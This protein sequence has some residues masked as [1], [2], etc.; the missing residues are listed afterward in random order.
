MSRLVNPWSYVPV[1][2][3]VLGQIS[4]NPKVRNE[5]AHA[6]TQI[7]SG[8]EFDAYIAH[9]YPDRYAVTREHI[10]IAK[11]QLEDDKLAAIA[12]LK[13]SG[14]LLMVGMGWDFEVEDPDLINNYRIRGE[15]RNSKGTLFFIEVGKHK[16]NVA[17]TDIF[18]MRCDH[19]INRDIEKLAD[20][21]RQMAG[22]SVCQSKYYNWK[23]LESAPHLGPYTKSRLLEIVNWNFDCRFTGVE[24]DNYTLRVEEYVSVSP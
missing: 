6:N 14:T 24:I 10:E 22:T 11:R 5:I 18:G 9:I 23:K 3:E 21:V 1:P 13:S 12:R 19:S 2:D 20:S 15:F 4:F 16:D 7:K 8:G 17:D